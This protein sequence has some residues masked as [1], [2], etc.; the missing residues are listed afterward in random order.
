[1]LWQAGERERIQ[2]A[3]QALAR[4]RRVVA[5]LETQAACQAQQQRAFARVGVLLLS[6][7]SCCAE[8]VASLTVCTFLHLVG[9]HSEQLGREYKGLDDEC[10]TKQHVPS[11]VWVWSY[12]TSPGS[13]CGM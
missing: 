5:K 6:H 1:M 8:G 12:W 3:E 4:R 7:C 2:A 13:L 10:Q 9:S 11:G